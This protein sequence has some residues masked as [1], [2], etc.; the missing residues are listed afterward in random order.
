[1]P[2]CFFH[3]EDGGSLRDDEGIVLPSVEEA[4]TQAVLA[5]SAAIRDA[6]ATFWSN[7]ARW[8]ME[9]VDELGARVCALR[10]S[11]E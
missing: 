8:S 3:V 1:M 11:G 4:R 7:G 9:V 5:A 10:F 2:R 6:G